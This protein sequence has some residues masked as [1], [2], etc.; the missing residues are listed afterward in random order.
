L[1]QGRIYS[2]EPHEIYLQSEPVII[3]D[4][5]MSDLSCRKRQLSRWCYR[6]IVLRVIAGNC[7]SPQI[8]LQ[9]VYR[10]EKIKAGRVLEQVLY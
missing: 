3:V 5:T 4:I 7:F 1:R 8:G 10:L 6:E 9:Q 2:I